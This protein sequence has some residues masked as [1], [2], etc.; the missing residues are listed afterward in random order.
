[1]TREMLG[2]TCPVEQ[3]HIPEYFI[4]SNTAVRTSNKAQLQFMLG[5]SLLHSVIIRA[6][7]GPYGSA[8]S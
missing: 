7:A 6:V 4:F 3:C 2:N 5:H 8:E 1:M